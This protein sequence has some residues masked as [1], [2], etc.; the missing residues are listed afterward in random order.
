M[1]GLKFMKLGVC[2]VEECLVVK[3]DKLVYKQK[4]RKKKRNLKY[5]LKLKFAICN[6]LMTKIAKV[7]LV[8]SHLNFHNC[9]HRP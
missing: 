9:Y 1:M 8:I 4:N 5:K 7:L 2:K 3:K 6:N